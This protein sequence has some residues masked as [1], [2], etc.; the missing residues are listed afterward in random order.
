M[1]LLVLF[2]VF[3]LF[4]FT[5]GVCVGLGVGACGD[6]GS[7]SWCRSSVRVSGMESVSLGLVNV[8]WAFG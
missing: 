5:L 6:I 7:G 4:G 3:F 1:F 8:G 2:I